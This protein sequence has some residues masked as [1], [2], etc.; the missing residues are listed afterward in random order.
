MQMCLLIMDHTSQMVWLTIEKIDLLDLK[1]IIKF[2]PRITTLHCIY[3]VIK[4]YLEA[5]GHKV[6]E[7][8]KTSCWNNVEIIVNNEL[9]FKCNIKDLDFGG[10][11]E[12][13]E[14][15]VKAENAVKNA[16]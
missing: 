8:T 4:A 12:L 5:N 16:Y 7:F 2:Y 6:I 13:D 1:V 11:G 15:A 14:L 3:C 10:D 9:V